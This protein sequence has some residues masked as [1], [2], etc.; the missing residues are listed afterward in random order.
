V[1]VPS[2]DRPAFVR[3]AVASVLAQTLPSLECIVVDDGGRHAIRLDGDPRLRVIRSPRP[4]GAAA[5]RNAGIASAEGSYITF[6]DD[7]DAFTPNR[8][9]IALRG[10]RTGPLA[11]CWRAVVGGRGVIATDL[12]G[13]VSDRILNGP[14]PNVGQVA[15]LREQTPRFDERFEVSE[16]VEWWLRAATVG[17][18]CT[19]PEVGYLLRQHEGPRLTARLDA[20]L[21]ARVLLLELHEPYF[22]SH[23][24]AAAYQW[25]RVGGLASRTGDT[26]LTRKAFARAFRLHP[27]LRSTIHLVRFGVL[28]GRG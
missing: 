19:V 6:L 27:T 15:L 9:A 26:R 13:D 21:A 18:V 17:P 22:A 11:L 23:P 28:G 7:D 10:L 3:T 14:V 8:L 12:G 4:H 20:R 25:R 24:S 1:V 5:A 16:D 2:R